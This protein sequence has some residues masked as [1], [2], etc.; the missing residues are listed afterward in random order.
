MLENISHFKQKLEDELLEVED[1]LKAAGMQNEA[2]EWEVRD[3]DIDETATESDELGDRMEEFGEKKAEVGEIEIH[4]RNIERAIEKIEL[5]TYG[6]C[7]V[8][9]EEIEENRLEINP[10]ARTCKTHMDEESGLP[11]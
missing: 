7:E 5:G 8:C 3:T 2:G 1:R 6:T 9:G 11:A 4:W 10:S